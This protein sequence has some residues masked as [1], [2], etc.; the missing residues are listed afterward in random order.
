MS[1]FYRESAGGPEVPMEFQGVVTLNPDGTQATG[2]GDASAANQTTQITRLDTIILNIG[3]EDEA[4]AT[5]DTGTFSLI[6]LFKR[7]IARLFA[8]R[9][10][11][12]GSISTSGDNVIV[13]DASVAAGQEVVITYLLIQNA[14]GNETLCLLESGESSATEKGRLR[15]EAKTSGIATEFSFGNELVMNPG[16][17]FVINLDAAEAHDVTCRYYLRDATTKLP[18]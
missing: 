17:G 9:S 4:A 7:V 14:T 1:G 16:E 18:V 3:N 12:S 13:A 8:T 2:G 15:T 6:S 10:V 5:T 11:F